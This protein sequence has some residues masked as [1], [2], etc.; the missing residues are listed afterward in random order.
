MLVP[1]A[2]SKLFPSDISFV[3]VEEIAKVEGIDVLFVGPYDLGNNILHPI[4]TGEPDEELR[5]AVERVRK[6]ATEAGKKTG[7]YCIS[8]EQ[9]RKYADQGFNMVRRRS[10]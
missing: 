1:E 3:Q 10:L 7:I 4:T 5:A 6:V 8:G 9:G 2:P